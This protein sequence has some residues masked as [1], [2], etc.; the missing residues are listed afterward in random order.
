MSIVWFFALRV[1]V[2]ASYLTL[3]FAKP[4]VAGDLAWPFA[5][6]ALTVAVYDLHAVRREP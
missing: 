3:A 5:A 4:N 1:A 2:A 6:I